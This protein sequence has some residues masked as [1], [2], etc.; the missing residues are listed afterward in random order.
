MKSFTPDLKNIL[1]QPDAILSDKDA[2][3]TRHVGQNTG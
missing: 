1:G 2:A 3:T